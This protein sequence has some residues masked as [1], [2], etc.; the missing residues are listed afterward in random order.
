M[1]GRRWRETIPSGSTSSA[2]CDSQQVG[3]SVSGKSTVSSPRH[4]NS[5]QILRPQVLL[6]A[7][8]DHH[9]L[10]ACRLSTADAQE[11][12]LGE[13][14]GTQDS[15][16]RKDTLPQP[17]HLVCHTCY[18]KQ[19]SKH[20]HFLWRFRS[21]LDKALSNLILDTTWQHSNISLPGLVSQE[22]PLAPTWVLQK[23]YQGSFQ[24]QSTHRHMHRVY[25][26]LTT[27]MLGRSF[28]C[29][30][31]RADL[32]LLCPHV[33]CGHF[34]SNASCCIFMAI[35]IPQPCNLTT[36]ASLSMSVEDAVLTCTWAHG[37]F[38][39]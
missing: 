15:H 22:E 2:C 19:M 3:S 6:G 29:R 26:V 36:V 12:N 37:P 14:S 9:S 20:W 32:D 28:L 35:T 5:F 23:K 18:H 33:V 34:C 16:S 30:S 24:P 8:G 13:R 21:R 11:F 1:C 39:K 10:V 27:P 7:V 38:W 25:I 17:S 4:R 31:A